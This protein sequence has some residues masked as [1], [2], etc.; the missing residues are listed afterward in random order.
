MKR[1]ST[2]ERASAA[3]RLRYLDPPHRLR[4]VDAFKQLSPDRGPVLLQVGGQLV[5]AHA[6]N[7]RCS[8]VAPDLLQRL[9]QIVT[10]DNSFHRRPTSRQAFEAGFRRAGFDLLGSGASGFTRHPGSQVHLDLILPSH[11]RARSPLYWP[12]LPFG[13]SADRSAY[14][15]VC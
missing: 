14:Y 3:R 13:P 10:L 12:L 15:A 1:S 7:T 9:P 5:D 8:F 2:A 4:L 11:D 6:V